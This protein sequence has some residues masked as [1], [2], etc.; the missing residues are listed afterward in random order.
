M[1]VIVL[2]FFGTAAR[3]DVRSSF[4]FEGAQVVP[5][6][7]SIAAGQGAATLNTAGTELVFAV[8]HGVTDVTGATVRSGDPGTNGSVAF[9]LTLIDDSKFNGTWMIDSNGIADLQGGRLY[10]QIESDLFPD[11]E[12]RGQIALNLNPGPGD[13]II[14]EIMYD[15]LSPEGNFPDPP[16]A[17][18][19][20]WIELFNTTFTD[21]DIGGWFFQDED[22]E[23]GDPCTPL[24]SGTFPSHVLRSFQTVV[25][26]PDGAELDGELPNVA[27]FKT[28]W[29][30]GTQINVI[31]LN[32]NGTTGGAIV[33][34]NLSNNPYNDGFAN[35]LPLI[36]NP[37][38][39]SPCGLFDRT[40]N[41]ILT[42]NDGAQ[43]IDIVN[44][45]DEFATEVG[46]MDWPDPPPGA[47]IQLVPVD[48]PA[49]PPM[50]VSSFTAA[51]N[52]DPM[53]WIGHEIG[54]SAGG[55]QQSIA[56]GVYKGNDIGS[57]GFLYGASAGNQPPV[58]VGEQVL[59]V[60]GQTRLVT[61]DGTDNTRPFFGLLL[62]LIKTLPQNGNLIDIASGNHVI[63]AGDVSAN[64]YLMPKIPFN[65][66]RYT[67]NGTCGMDSF[68]FSTFDGILESAPVTVEF[69]VQCGELV[70]T[71]IMYNPDST[72]NNPSEAEW[73]EL[74]NNTDLPIDLDGWY[75]SDD[76]TRSGDFPSYILGARSAVVAIPAVA[77][78]TEYHNGWGSQFVHIT[79]NGDTGNGGITGSNLGSPPKKLLVRLR[80][81]CGSGP[82]RSSLA[83]SERSEW[84]TADRV[85]CRPCLRTG[86]PRPKLAVSRFLSASYATEHVVCHQLNGRRTR[87]FQTGANHSA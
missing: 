82:C 22:V 43:I 37:P 65:L 74:Y 9:T 84:A 39:W 48:F 26:I 6:T 66:A 35:D 8:I 15:P 81:A 54:D 85:G 31:Q 55:A 24:Q 44:F 21:I 70:I 56:A 30:L 59:M 50:D 76:A 12:I 58:S 64:G 1:C 79:T 73:V 77:D 80:K 17:A 57:P 3:A 4:V 68:T 67:N 53:N 62:Y 20:K 18:N 36:P 69:F 34:R 5:P 11:G 28:S 75:L 52:D 60:P 42:L 49:L 87:I 14:T 16:F 45:G 63:T 86:S 7:A 33:G 27:D 32:A 38:I 46:T 83:M 29:N 61:M 25:V 71:E 23:D 10:V 72:E 51:G 13:V 40:D 41:E 2:V 78:V 47:S 19:S